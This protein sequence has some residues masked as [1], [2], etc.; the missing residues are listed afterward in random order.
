MPISIYRA[1]MQCNRSFGEF[2]HL[3]AAK[4]LQSVGPNQDLPAV[5]IYVRPNG[6]PDD[7]VR[8]PIRLRN[9]RI[10]R[11]QNDLYL[12][13]KSDPKVGQ[14]R[15][16]LALYSFNPAKPAD[17]T[18][19]DNLAGLRDVAFLNAAP[20]VD[21]FIFQNRPVKVFTGRG[22]SESNATKAVWEV[23]T[24]ATRAVTKT[25]YQAQIRD[26]W[27]GINSLTASERQA[28]QT[29][30]QGKI[31]NAQKGVPKFIIW[32]RINGNDPQRN[33]TY[34]ALNTLI[35]IL[36]SLQIRPVLFGEIFR[37]NDGQPQL[38]GSSGE[39]SDFREHYKEGIFDMSAHINSYA[40]QLYL[41]HYLYEEYN[42]LGIVGAKSGFIDG[43]ALM[44]IPVIVLE[45]WKDNNV[46]QPIR[47]GNLPRMHN[48]VRPIMPN[49]I[50]FP[51]LNLFSPPPSPPPSSQT[52]PPLPG[53]P[54]VR[55]NLT[56]QEKRALR[57]LFTLL[58][59]IS[60]GQP[61]D[62][63]LITLNNYFNRVY[64]RNPA[65]HHTPIT[66]DNVRQQFSRT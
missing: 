50:I 24:S 56:D 18:I 29:Y 33:M 20:Y 26:S 27:I 57:H 35:S 5:A 8:I 58:M 62:K 45:Y 32:S 47:Q 64:P 39:I 10:N 54:G 12:L 36:K 53:T 17:P 22:W 46:I 31:P 15:T 25:G 48:W 65:A 2:F 16:G 13:I 41:L 6:L 34:T 21:H 44:G 37:R 52:V 3:S 59:N 9:M 7:D 40:R 14:S 49:Y 66:S 43:A 60:A 55:G 28:I 19:I 23:F 4:L 51:T 42:V 11:L 38:L 30:V 61:V 1:A 63:I